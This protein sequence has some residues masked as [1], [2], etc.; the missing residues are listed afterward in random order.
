MGT[1]IKDLGRHL[2]DTGLTENETSICWR[3]RESAYQ[4]DLLEYTVLGERLRNY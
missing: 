3:E 4:A 1:T 2:Q